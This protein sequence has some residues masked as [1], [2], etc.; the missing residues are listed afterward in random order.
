MVFHMELYIV[1]VIHMM[2]APKA[3]KI[4]YVLE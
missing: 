2:A 4:G 3:L 1:W